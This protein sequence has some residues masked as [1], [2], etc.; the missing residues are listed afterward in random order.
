M[1]HNNLSNKEA[2][3]ILNTNLL[4]IKITQDGKG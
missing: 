3:L 1:H 2:H 4:V